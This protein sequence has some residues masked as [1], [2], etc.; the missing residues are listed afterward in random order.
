MANEFAMSKEAHTSYCMRKMR[1]HSGTFRPER[2]MVT[3]L[4]SV[5]YGWVDYTSI[6]NPDYRWPKD[7]RQEGDVYEIDDQIHEVV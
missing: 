3:C 4:G 5:I 1:Q 6:V 7:L 2:A